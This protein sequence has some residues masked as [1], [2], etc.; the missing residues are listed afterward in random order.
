ML[1][2]QCSLVLFGLKVLAVRDSLLL[3][4][5]AEQDRR[6]P[7]IPFVVFLLLDWIGGWTYRL[8]QSRY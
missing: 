2:D 7:E 5:L 8:W 3:R 6:I 4:P 1:F